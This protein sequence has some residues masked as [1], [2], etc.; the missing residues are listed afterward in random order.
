MKITDLRSTI[1]ALTRRVADNLERMFQPVCQAHGLT[2]AQLRVL[3]S[4]HERTYTVGQLTDMLCMQNGNTSALCRRMEKENLLLRMRD[5]QDQR[6]VQ[7]RL[8]PRGVA[9]VET[10]QHELETRYAQKLQQQSAQT[11]QQVIDTMTR[12]CALLEQ[13]HTDEEVSG[14]GGQ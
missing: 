14:H 6:V 10:I 1:W 9:L 7:L 4:L 8:T 11:V 12:L 3:F 13:I 5:P 2:S